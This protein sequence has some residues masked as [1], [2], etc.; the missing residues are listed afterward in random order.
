MPATVDRETPNQALGPGA[1]AT[2]GVALTV[3]LLATLVYFLWRDH[4]AKLESA[5]RQVAAMALGSDRLLSLAMLNLEHA[6]KG[7]AVDSRRLLSTDPEHASALLQETITGAHRRHPELLDIVIVDESGRALSA[8]NGNAGVVQWAS[9]PQNRIGADGLIIGRPQ[10]LTNGQW[11][12]PLAVPLATEPGERHAWVLARYR[13]AALWGIASGLDVGEHGVANVFHRDGTMLARSRDPAT[14]VSHDYSQSELM[15]VLLP[16]SPVGTSNQVS[17]VDG[18]RRI[19]AYRALEHYPLVVAVGV[20]LEEFL[21]S[22]YQRA[23]AVALVIIFFSLGW[24]LLL[25]ILSRANAGQQ[26]LLRQLRKSSETLLEAQVIANLGS[27]SLDLETGKVE[28]SPQAQS[29]YGWRPGMAPLT[30]QT[31]LAQTYPE[32]RARLEA[33]H[34]RHVAEG[35]FED[36]RYRIV[37]PDGSMRSIVARGRVVEEDGRRIM[38]GTVQDITDLAEAH[39]QLQQAE[40]QYRLLFDQNPLP[41]WVFHRETLQ[42]LEANEAAIAQYGYTR[43]EFQ[44]MSLA[45]IRPPEDVVDALAVAREDHPEKRRGRV[46]RHIRKDGSLFYVAIHSADI[47]FRGEAARLVLALDITDRLRQQQQLEASERR[48]QLV[49][50]ATSDAVFDWNI[51]S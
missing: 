42:I 9:L 31:C 13:L 8:G 46:W 3:A 34:A 20:S 19:L 1:P 10:R 48:F 45:D 35:S 30:L 18:E 17:P 2:Y 27:W 44:S 12:L 39:A 43:E 50:R 40:A 21:G 51:R 16:R 24:L 5:E 22:W 14:S 23:G 37:R 36:T 32:D 33:E 25:R 47:T 49:A 11:F 41:F 6:L 28:F 15:R 26:S 29:I 38:V 7:I 4:Q